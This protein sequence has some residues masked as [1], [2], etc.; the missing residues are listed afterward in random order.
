[1]NQFK[2]VEFDFRN[3]E[4]VL[5]KRL[6]QT[7]PSG[8]E[9]LSQAGL[10]LCRLGV[11]TIDINLDGRGPVKMLLDTG[12]AST[13]L[14]WPGV[15]DLK[16]NWNHPLISRN[17]NNMGVMG[18]DNNAMALTH[19]FVAQRWFQ[20]CAEAGSPLGMSNRGLD[21]QQMGPVN[22]DIGDLPVLEQLKDED[23]NGILGIDL[24]MRC[25]V[26]RL[27]FSANSATA[28]LLMERKE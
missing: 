10:K 8:T 1:M 22:I 23:V 17:S 18:A 21:L 2:C 6:P 9:V 19:R 4:L 16:M 3:N 15:T 5:S 20:I 14:N 25:D 27:T 12:A 24:L 11:W 7:L 13:F 28:A 26:L